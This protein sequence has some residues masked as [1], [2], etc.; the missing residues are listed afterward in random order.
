[1][2]IMAELLSAKI[3]DDGA[4]TVLILPLAAAPIRIGNAP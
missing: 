4:D 1:M 3:L 2:T